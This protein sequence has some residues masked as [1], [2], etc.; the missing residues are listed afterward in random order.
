M[1]RTATGAANA[2]FRRVQPVDYATF[3][4]PKLW[5]L[6]KIGESGRS[7][8]ACTRRPFRRYITHHQTGAALCMETSAAL[9]VIEPA[10]HYALPDQRRR[11]DIVKPRREVLGNR[12]AQKASPVGATPTAAEAV[13]LSGTPEGVP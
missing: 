12:M 13:F 9:R 8:S 2:H 10:P 3:I 7:Y 4:V 11:R 1:G 5:K 6:A